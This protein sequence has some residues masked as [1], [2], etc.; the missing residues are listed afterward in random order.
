MTQQPSNHW[1]QFW[2]QG[3]ITTFGAA[4]AG[5]YEGPILNFWRDQFEKLES[6]ARLLDIATGNGALALL[7]ASYA[8]EHEFEWQINACDLAR[9][10]ETA[11]AESGIRALSSIACE[12]LPYEDQSFNLV[13]SQFGFEYS[14]K[15]QSLA[16][17][18]RVLAPSGQ[19]GA[20]CHHQD[21]YT[22][23]SSRKELEIYRQALEKNNVFRS[24]IAFFEARATGSTELPQLQ[25]ALNYS[26]N[27]LRQAHGGHPC[28]DQIVGALSKSI[29]QAKNQSI[30][31]TTANL[32]ALELDF[33][34][35]AQRL[36]DLSNAALS[37]DGVK[38]LIEICEGLG[39]AAVEFGQLLHTPG[40]IAGYTLLARR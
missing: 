28:C 16:E 9:I 14:D 11:L 2:E 18:F 36:L 35:A 40:E 5:N 31:T 34:G 6:P 10:N 24:A 33:K 25:Q 20:V 23:N 15:E 8:R 30:A 26:V 19:F 1:S 39:F 13:T 27:R 4:L 12:R 7:A 38:A 21:S 17:I 37:E 22:L 29:G 3:H 32:V